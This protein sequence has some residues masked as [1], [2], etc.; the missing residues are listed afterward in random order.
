MGREQKKKVPWPFPG[1]PL[2]PGPLG[3]FKGVCRIGDGKM[4][5][6]KKQSPGS[7]AKHFLFCSTPFEGRRALEAVSKYIGKSGSEQKEKVLAAC[8]ALSFLLASVRRRALEAVS[9]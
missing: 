9:K 4:A 1:P 5:A 8:R 2:P 3:L 6:S 7:L